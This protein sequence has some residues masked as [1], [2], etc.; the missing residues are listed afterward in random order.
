MRSVSYVAANACIL[1]LSVYV[2]LDCIQLLRCMEYIVAKGVCDHPKRY[3]C[4]CLHPPMPILLDT[5]MRR[6]VRSPRYGTPQE[7]E[8]SG[9]G[10]G[11]ASVSVTVGV[12]RW[13]TG[14]FMDSRI[15]SL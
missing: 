5:S 12:S 14:R 4:V 15:Y 8:H 1:V 7:A 11:Q 3:S 13:R 6:A 9:L 2:D 10:K